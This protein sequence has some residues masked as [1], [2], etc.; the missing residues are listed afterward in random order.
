MGQLLALREGMYGGTQRSADPLPK[1]TKKKSDNY[2][3]SAK[4]NYATVNRPEGSAHTQSLARFSAKYTS[5]VM[6]NI[7]S[8]VCSSSKDLLI[9]VLRSINV[10]NIIYFVLSF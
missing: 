2:T 5:F 7:V 1:Q 9:F 8:V 6:Q 4:S 3:H 10:K